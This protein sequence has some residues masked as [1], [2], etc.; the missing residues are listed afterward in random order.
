MHSMHGLKNY[1]DPN[2]QDLYS[3][4]MMYDTYICQSCHKIRV[5]ASTIFTTTA[6]IEPWP[7]ATCQIYSHPL[8]R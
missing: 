3:P 1:L 5:P 8:H 4:N 2:S 7:F 6:R